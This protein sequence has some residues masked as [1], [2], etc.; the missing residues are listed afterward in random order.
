MGSADG[1]APFALSKR[2]AR[3]RLAIGL[4]AVA[5]LSSFSPLIFGSSFTAA[6][7]VAYMHFFMIRLTT[8]K[9]YGEEAKTC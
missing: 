8:L 4:E 3:G 1:L 7:C 5:R 9:V 6:D 2:E